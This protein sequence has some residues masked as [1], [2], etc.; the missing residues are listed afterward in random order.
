[1]K[2]FFSYKTLKKKSFSLLSG[3]IFPC[4]EAFKF[5]V[6]GWDSQAGIPG[7]G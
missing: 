5:V 6:S 1:M 7:T 3:G 4:L 2:F